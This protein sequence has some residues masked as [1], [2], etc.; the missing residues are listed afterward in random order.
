MIYFHLEVKI[1]NQVNIDNQ[2]SQ[3]I[4]KSSANQSSLIHSKNP[5]TLLST[6]KKRVILTFVTGIFCFLLVIFIYFYLKDI[7]SRKIPS[8][9]LSYKNNYYG[10]SIQYDPELAAEPDIYGSQDGEDLGVELHSINKDKLRTIGIENTK[11]FLRAHDFHR[12]VLLDSSYDKW[13][14]KILKPALDSENKVAD[15][16]KKHC[17]HSKTNGGFIYYECAKN[18]PD[19]SFTIYLTSQSTNNAYLTV[20]LEKPRDSFSQEERLVIKR[21]I[22]SSSKESQTTMMTYPT[23]SDL[24]QWVKVNWCHGKNK[25]Y[26][27]YA[28]GLKQYSRYSVLS[29]KKVV[30]TIYLTKPRSFCEIPINSMPHLPLESCPFPDT[31]QVF[32]NHTLG[33][34]EQ[35]SVCG[36][37]LPSSSY[38]Y[39]SVGITSL[40]QKAISKM[41]IPNG[42][43]YTIMNSGGVAI[44][45]PLSWRVQESPIGSCN[46]DSS[47]NSDFIEFRDPDMQVLLTVTQDGMLTKNTA[48]EEAVNLGKIECGAYAK[49]E[50][51]REK[52]NNND[53]YE[54]YLLLIGQPNVVAIPRRI[55]VKFFSNQN[56]A[57]LLPQI[58]R[59]FQ[60]MIFLH[61]NLI[62]D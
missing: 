21:I 14:F 45:T 48:T 41:S 40:F 62:N 38:E 13:S 19:W 34:S 2:N 24:F 22:N 3:Q 61:E 53:Q 6:N 18:N 56:Q 28:N 26:E 5:T 32:D 55:T 23:K 35:Y 51:I 36:D 17:E 50:L 15:R 29:V 54:Y 57:I 30:D 42:W 59:I 7:E 60:S 31:T 47:C 16:L 1:E 33:E 20:Q 43:K 11:E 10:Y 49:C 44:A 52:D 39:S 4:G 46:S 8:S 37:T 27:E 58:D 9:W 12:G 25:L